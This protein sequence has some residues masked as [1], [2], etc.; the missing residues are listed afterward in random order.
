[1]ASDPPRN[2]Q[3]GR[4]GFG[5]GVPQGEAP[6]RTDESGDG[7]AG[8]VEIEPMETNDVLIVAIGTALFA[9]AF[10]VL[11][12][13]RTSLERSGHGRWPWIALSGV[14]GGLLGL[15]YC[16]RRQQRMSKVNAQ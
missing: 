6:E 14:I 4:G 7:A 2:G 16:V 9:V 5:D 10:V 13:L 12:A 15:V 11:L 1:M 8:R 3:S